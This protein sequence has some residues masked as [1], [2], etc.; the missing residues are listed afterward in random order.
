MFI[1]GQDGNVIFSLSDKGLMK[2]T[3]YTKDIYNNGK[4]YGSNVY[5]KSLFQT[6]L[7]G[8]YED[9]E[10]E[11]VISEIYKL[12]KAGARFYSMPAPTMDLQDLGVET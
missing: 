2:G 9:A 6:Y 11:Q 1:Q 10:A 5:G 8:T 3:V 7:L 12:L 4:F